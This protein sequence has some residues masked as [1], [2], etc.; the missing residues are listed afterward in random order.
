MVRSPSACA[1][2][3]WQ[4][5]LEARRVRGAHVRHPLRQ[6]RQLALP[7]GGVQSI[8]QLCHGCRGDGGACTARHAAS[9][10]LRYA[11][12]RPSLATAAAGPGIPLPPPQ[13]PALPCPA[14]HAALRAAGWPKSAGAAWVGP[15]RVPVHL[16]GKDCAS[17]ASSCSCSWLA[18]GSSS[19]CS[20][21][22]S[23]SDTPSLESAAAA[24]AGCC[25]QGRDRAGCMGVA[26][27]A[28]A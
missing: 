11:R 9:C 5:C 27:N 14:R 17:P 20:A 24:A 10:S 4:P 8:Q 15:A 16:L 23:S 12:G 28:A 18:E 1:V 3:S 19:S 7:V 6:L 21:A 22:S 25:T 2:H 26:R 13:S